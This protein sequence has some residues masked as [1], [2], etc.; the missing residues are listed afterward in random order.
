MR[1]SPSPA[2]P[3]IALLGA[4]NLAQGL[5]VALEEARALLGAPLHAFGALGRGRSYGKD[6]WFLVRRMPGMRE[7][8]LWRRLET[9]EGGLTHALLTDVGN[10]LPFGQSPRTILGWVEEALE[11]LE[12][13][14]ARC[15]LT[16]LPMANLRALS[17]AAFAFWRR[18]IFPSHDISR[19]ELLAGAEE[20]ELGLR[21]LA[22][23]DG[24]AFVAPEATWYGLDPVHVARS[25][26]RAAWRAMLAP[27]QAGAP[28]ADGVEPRPKW[29]DPLRLV[30]ERRWILGLEQRGPQPCARAADGSTLSLY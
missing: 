3:R 5:L 14:G 20:L 6:S 23:R 22:A 8:G 16:G 27:W 10:D 18:A 24:R 17:P 4:S 7:C 21:A 9:L 12:A 29:P 13:R 28:R 26:R 15:T 25:R 2:P 30:P 1:A 19:D 11:R